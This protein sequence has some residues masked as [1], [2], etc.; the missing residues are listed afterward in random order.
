L[1]HVGHGHAQML[2][3]SALDKLQMLRFTNLVAAS[4]PDGKRVEP[5]V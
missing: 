5:C 3:L 1:I 2:R 4:G